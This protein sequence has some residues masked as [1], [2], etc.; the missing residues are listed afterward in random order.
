VNN[1][2]ENL[3]KEAVDLRKDGYTYSYIN[4]KLG[5][6]KSTLSYWLSEIPFKPNKE[7]VIKIGKAR[8]KSAECKNKIKRDSI[9][10]A[11]KWAK[12][13]LQNFST[14]DLMIFGLGIY[15]GEGTK[16]QDTVRIVNSNPDIIKFSIKWF[17]LFDI[18]SE[19]FSLTIHAYPDSSEKE[20]I[21]YWLDITRLPLKCF[22]KT[23]IDRR[24]NKIKSKLGKLPFGT[25]H[26]TIKANGNK[27]LG[28]ILSRRI[29]ALSDLLLKN[30]LRD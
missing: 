17:K 24:N 10:N 14:R 16:S 25:L 3:Y 29:K 2:K 30:K 9:K 28:V 12:N 22:K 15:A 23:Q 13:K 19:N 18:D 4:K 11:E 27:E 8:A 21:K 5:I 20:L 26:V 1:K 6:G 7:M